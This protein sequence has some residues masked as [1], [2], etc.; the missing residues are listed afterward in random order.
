VLEAGEVTK[1]ELAEMAGEKGHV[2]ATD[3]QKKAQHDRKPSHLAAKASGMSPS[4]YHDASYVLDPDRGERKIDE[5]KDELAEMARESGQMRANRAP[6]LGGEVEALQ[7]G[8]GAIQPGCGG[9]GAVVSG[10]LDRHRRELDR[11]G[12]L[13]AGR[14]G[15]GRNEGGKEER[16]GEAAGSQVWRL[17]AVTTQPVSPAEIDSRVVAT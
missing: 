9:L 7:C 11:V 2:V 1:D 16:R 3:D 5:A 4:L 12:A 15:H 17:P 8:P 13:G 14:G 10:G 6:S